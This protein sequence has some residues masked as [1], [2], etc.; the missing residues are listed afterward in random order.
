M[1]RFL[2]IY[3][4]SYIHKRICKLVGV[5]ALLKEHG[6]FKRNASV[7]C[8][9]LYLFKEIGKINKSLSR[10]KYGAESGEIAVRAFA[11]IAYVNMRERAIPEPI[12]REEI[13]KLMMGLTEL[14]TVY[15]DI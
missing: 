8:V 2:C 12:G 15:E 5:D 14:K 10:V 11:Q 13:V 3:E 6:G 7:V 4:F 1:S 9:A